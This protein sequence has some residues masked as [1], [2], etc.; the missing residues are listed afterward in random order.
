[1]VTHKRLRKQ[2]QVL[3]SDS[4]E[5]SNDSGVDDP[6]VTTSNRVGSRNS[7]NSNNNNKKGMLSDSE[8]DSNDSASAS[9]SADESNEDEDVEIDLEQD[10]EQSESEDDMSDIEE[11]RTNKKKKV[12]NTKSQPVAAAPPAQ[13]GRKPK[14]AST[15][16]PLPSPPAPAAPKKRPGRKKLEQSPLAAD[17]SNSAEITVNIV[18][19]FKNLNFSFPIESVKKPWKSVKQILASENTSNLKATFPSYQ[20]IEVSSTLI[21]TKKYCDITGYIANYVDPKSQLRYYDSSVYKLIQTFPD[22]LQQSYLNL[23]RGNTGYR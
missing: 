7:S 11:K 18:K 12:T 15:S 23:R 6:V 8:E 17:G 4:E 2:T 20:N 22:N 9:G 10:S 5:E 19:P 16:P 14:S 21:P 3:L 1:M 13:R